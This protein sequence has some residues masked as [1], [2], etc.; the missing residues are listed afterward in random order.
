MVQFLATIGIWHFA[1]RYQMAIAVKPAS[2]AHCLT[3]TFEI[4]FSVY[5]R[6]YYEQRELVGCHLLMHSLYGT[7]KSVGAIIVT[8]VQ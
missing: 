1:S 5:S 6:Q 4:E 7:E 8:T 3:W 2:S